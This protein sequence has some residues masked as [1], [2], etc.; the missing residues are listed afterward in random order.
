[1]RETINSYLFALRIV[2]ESA[3]KWTAYSIV[4]I[5]LQGVL[6]ILS[7][8]VF[9]HVIDMVTTGQASFNE[10]LMPLIGMGL[11]Q[12]AIATIS[13]LSQLLSEMQQQKVR[14]RMAY[15]VQN[16]ALNLDLSYYENPDYHNTYYKA[17]QEG[18]TRPVQVVRGIMNLLN[19]MVSLVFIAGLLGTMESWAAVL[20]VTISLPNAYVKYKFSNKSFLWRKN[21][22]PIERE[23]HYLN[24]LLTLTEYVKEMKLLRVGSVI[25]SKF[26]IIR[27]NLYDEK[28][29]L[30]VQL[31]INTFLAKSVEV[32]VEFG[33][34]ALV[35]YRSIN[36]TITIGELVIFFQAFQ[37]GKNNMTGMFSAV[38]VLHESRLFLSFIQQFLQLESKITEPAIPKKLPSVIQEIS[39]ESVSFQYPQSPREALTD[40]STT[41]RPGLTAIVGENG[42]GK[43]TL[44]KLLCRLY[45]P[46]DGKIMIDDQPLTDFRP[47]EYQ[48]RISIVFQDFARYEFS[49]LENIELGSEGKTDRDLEQVSKISGLA[50]VI[51]RYDKGLDQRLGKQFDQG[52]E[53]SIGQWQKVA[54]TRAF[55]NDAEI[56]ILDEPTSAIDPLAEKKI[57]EYL[58]VLARTKI[59]ILVTHRLYN[60]KQA[61]QILVMRQG[62]L[63]ESGSHK[64]L[65]QQKGPYH[66]M[67]KNQET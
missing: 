27:E 30:S 65:M 42:S 33:I 6:P 53:L 45:D 41:F 17:Q 5:L 66:Q 7:L 16:K 29:K 44:V 11:I 26:R 56:I 1:M 40:L 58:Q 14:D 36:G 47:K 15:I 54:L 61:N 3:P 62:E 46:S 55:Y 60:L 25:Q 2:W 59:V 32:G 48:E 10:V 38:V 18:F 34:Y 35:I 64:E 51:N 50:E 37:R 13:S 63:I 12:L 28:K 21:R 24:R 67:F 4:I 49:F 8:L 22:I 52:T 57:F 20:M 43:S 31:S 39:F 19:N 9:K 23:S